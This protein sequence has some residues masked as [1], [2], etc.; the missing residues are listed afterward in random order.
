MTAFALL[1]SA[2]RMEGQEGQLPQRRPIAATIILAENYPSFGAAA[3]SAGRVPL[4][5]IILFDSTTGAATVLLNPNYAATLT[6]YESFA[7][8]RSAVDHAD[9]KPRFIAVRATR[10]VRPID[11][12][13]E[14]RLTALLGRLRSPDAA[15]ARV[16]R[17]HGKVAYEHDIGVYL[18]RRN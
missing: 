7:R 13:V 17:A 15:E 8:I 4:S 1:T 9:E 11:P 6:L 3:D 16:F 2:K 12:A 10:Q 14:T 5:A 18:P